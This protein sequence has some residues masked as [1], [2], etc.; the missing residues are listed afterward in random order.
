MC[1]NPSLSIELVRDWK[2]VF[3][4][5]FTDVEPFR[6]A[7]YI[8]GFFLSFKEGTLETESLLGT[9]VRDYLEVFLGLE[10]TYC[11]YCFLWLS[12]CALLGIDRGVVGLADLAVCCYFLV[13]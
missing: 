5:T 4:F 8:L 7:D 10:T 11:S 9:E 13:S 1:V 2:I 6:V 3:A 12:P